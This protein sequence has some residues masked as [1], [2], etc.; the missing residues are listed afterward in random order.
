MCCNLYLRINIV[1]MPKTHFDCIQSLRPELLIEV[2]KDVKDL[3]MN[4]RDTPILSVDEYESRLNNYLNSEIDKILQIAAKKM[5]VPLYVFKQNLK[6]LPEFFR[7]HLA[8]L[9]TSINY[10]FH[11]CVNFLLAGKKTFFFS[12]SISQ[13][14][15]HTEINLP[16]TEIQ[17]PFFN[18]QLVFT[19][20]EV[21]DAFYARAVKDN[22][23]LVIDYSCPISVFVTLYNDCD[24][25]NG[26]RIILNS[27]HSKFPDTVFLMQKRELYLGND[28]NLEQSLRTDWENL[29][30]DNLGI[31]T[32]YNNGNLD[33]SDSELFYT[34]GLLFYR[35]V[36]NAILYIISNKSEIPKKNSPIRKI[37]KSLVN[38]KSFLKREKLK[39]NLERVSNLDY[40]EV[41]VS[42]KPII[43]K[44]QNGEEQYLD[45]Q[46]LDKKI[47]RRFMVRGHWRNQR[48]GPGLVETK[49]IWIKP[50]IKG[51]DLSEMINKPYFVK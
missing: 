13:K 21:I 10:E 20:K 41:G 16:A 3:I 5:G 25:L 24:G 2:K 31:G 46:K 18:C 22:P 28:W 50:Y 23:D 47:F 39:Q 42:E 7:H 15:V 36:M 19:E 45:Y 40:F 48:Y 26:R 11:F 9:S 43:L 38:A 44:H 33:Y 12:D 1:E 51:D 17:L 32:V 14:L 30:P 29:T 8:A 6:G 34:D 35:I 27:Y 4:G 37:E 49:L